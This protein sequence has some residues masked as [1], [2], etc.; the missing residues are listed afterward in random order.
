ME[1]GEPDDSGRRRPLA[2]GRTETMKADLVIMA[3]GNASNPIIKDSE[4]QLHTTTWGTIDLDH[5]GSQETS[6]HGVYSGGDAARGGSTAINAAGDGQAAA[7]EII[8]HVDVPADQVAEMVRTAQGVHRARLDRADDPRHGPPRRRHRGDHRPLAGHRRRGPGRPVRPRPAVG[9]RRAD[10]AHP[11]R[12]GRRGRHDLPRRAGRRD[13]QHRDQPDAG[14]GLLRRHRRA[15]RTPQR[16]HRVPGRPDGRLHRRRARAAAGVPD[17]AR[18]PAG[19]EP[20]DPHRRVP[21]RRAALLDRRRRARR[22]PAARVRRPARGR[23]HDERRDLRGRGLRHHAARGDARGGRGGN[24]ARH[25]RGRRD[26]AAAHDAR[27]VGPD[28]PVRRAARSRA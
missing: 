15:A 12:L 23:L 13:E 8:G 18:A 22:R 28:A 24:R 20:R 3:L 14:R 19:R 16:G 6:L 5:A 25:R 7:R 4:P 9:G 1:L 17:H 21:Q 11:R 27:G 10:P 2:T 26:R